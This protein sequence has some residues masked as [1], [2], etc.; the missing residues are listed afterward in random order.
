M[1]SRK[2]FLSRIPLFSC[3]VL[4]LALIVTCQGTA[5]AASIVKKF[6]DNTGDDFPGTIEDAAIWQK[7]PDLNYGAKANSPV[8]ER[9]TVGNECRVLIRFKDIAS[10]LGPGAV[11]TSAT[12]NLYCSVEGSSA[13]YSVSAY[14]VLLDWVEGTKNGAVESGSS[15]WNYAQ[16]NTLAWN[17]AGCDAASDVASEGGTADRR[18][19]AEQSTAITGT[20]QYFSWDLTAAVQNWYDGSWSEYGVILT[21]DSP[22]ISRTRK[23]FAASENT[24]DGQRPYLE[25]TYEGPGSTLTVCQSGC[26]Q[27][28]IQAAL[29]AAIPGDTVKVTDG[30]TYTS[31]SGNLIEMK[32]N[33]DLV[34]DIGVTPT[35]HGSMAPA[36]TFEGQLNDCT[37]DGFIITG[38]LLGQG[39]Q[40]YV[41]GS[42]SHGATGAVTNVTIQNCVIDGTV[43]LNVGGGII[44]N[45][46]VAPTIKDTQIV[47]SYSSCITTSIAF[48]VTHAGSP[49]RIEGCDLQALSP[50]GLGGAGIRISGTGSDAIQVVIGGDNTNANY[51]H[52]NPQV[53]IRLDNLGPGSVVTIDNNTVENNGSRDPNA[54]IL[55]ENVA[56]ATIKRNTINNSGLAGITINGNGVHQD[57]TVGGSLA[58]GNEIHDNQRAGV[59]FGGRTGPVKGIFLIKGNNIRNNQR[60]GIFVSS[61]V[62]GKVTITQNDI[63][64]NVRGGI[65]LKKNCELEITKNNIRNHANRGGIHTGELDTFNGTMGGPLLTIRQNKIHHNGGSNLGGGIDVRHASGSVANNVVYKNHRAGVRFG[66]W[67]DEITNNTVVWNGENDMGGGIIFDDPS[68]DGLNTR[69][70]GTLA[71]TETDPGPVIRNNISAYSEK[72]GLRVGGNGY[73]CPDNPDYGDG[74]KFRDYNQLY[75]NFPWNHV[76]NRANAP[77][78]GWPDL[79]DMSC[80]QQQYGG[81]GAYVDSGIVLNSPNDVMAEPSF[82]DMTNDN[83]QLT[84]PSTYPGDDGTQRGAYGGSDP[85]VDSEIP[86]L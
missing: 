52:D 68:L 27:S 19:T 4:L 18:A 64:D 69:A 65:A 67:I 1:K 11:I 60:G 71:V 43:G 47:N 61:K 28:T 80:T 66:D 14:R 40:I 77:D 81:C 25:V 20:G 15:S 72:A 9:G 85:I 55:V 54:G 12:M 7:N 26:D 30:S 83:F 6:G 84:D 5:R 8:G 73:P 39:G 46:A 48:Q 24:T 37:L 21:I 32:S 36:I 53:G 13:D 49:I 34:S 76:H 57:I 51:I 22:G 63:H 78:C 31:T 50:S 59:N 74:G 58:D 33:V 16:Q 29:A 56:S 44:L 17:T 86:E 3:L 2:V 10:K 79:N 23:V 45:G 62:T 75:G 35:I 82:V 41:N 42:A 70:D 38:G